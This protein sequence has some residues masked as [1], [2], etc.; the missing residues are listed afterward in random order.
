VLFAEDDKYL[1]ETATYA[2]SKAGLHVI[3]VNDGA[4]VIPTALKEQPDILIFDIHLPGKNGIDILRELRQ[5]SWGKNAKVMILT[6]HGEMENVAKALQ[7]GAL[8]YLMKVDWNL[9]SLVQKVKDHL[10]MP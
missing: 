7:F 4:Q 6:N 10:D 1:M 5:D 8:E 3:P 9:D 2:L